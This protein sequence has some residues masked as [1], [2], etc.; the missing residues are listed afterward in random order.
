MFT[1]DAPAFIPKMTIV[2]S[3]RR[4]SVRSVRVRVG[5][6][7]MIGYLLPGHRKVAVPVFLKWRK[8]R[9]R[10]VRGLPILS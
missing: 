5:A 8:I 2:A 1:I 6:K 10:A 7:V 3:P 9:S 4:S